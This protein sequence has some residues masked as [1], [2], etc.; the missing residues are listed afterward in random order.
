MKE[1]EGSC[2]S[3]QDEQWPENGKGQLTSGCYYYSEAVVFW[4]KIPLHFSQLSEVFYH[5][6]AEHKHQVQVRSV[7]GKS[8]ST[9]CVRVFE[10]QQRC[11]H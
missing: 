9:K 5:L 3:G 6:Y 11:R 7:L 1:S 10:V 8:S 2:V 4:R